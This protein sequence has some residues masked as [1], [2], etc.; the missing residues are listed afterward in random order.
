MARVNQNSV[1]PHQ[2]DLYYT[3]PGRQLDMFKQKKRTSAWLAHRQNLSDTPRTPQKEVA[4]VKWQKRQ[5]ERAF[6]AWDAECRRR[7]QRREVLVAKGIK[8]GKGK[9]PSKPA[10]RKPPSRLRCP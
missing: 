6:H 2:R 3:G 10:Q 9:N 7:K 1:D 5:A 4:K 8:P